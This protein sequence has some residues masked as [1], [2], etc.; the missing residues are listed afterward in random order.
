MQGECFVMVE[1]RPVCLYWVLQQNVF[2]RVWVKAEYVHILAKEK[3]RKT[4]FLIHIGLL[5]VA[6]SAGW[7]PQQNYTGSP[8]IPSLLMITVQLHFVPLSLM[9]IQ[10]VFCILNLIADRK[11]KQGNKTMK[12]RH[13]EQITNMYMAKW[14]IWGNGLLYSKK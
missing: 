6:Q 7:F 14:E 3:E 5:L 11:I 9:Q 8:S 4:Y 1:E 2:L 10:D 12:K 13:L